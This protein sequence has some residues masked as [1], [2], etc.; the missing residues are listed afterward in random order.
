MQ[1]VIYGDC[2]Q[3]ISISTSSA[4]QQFD[5]WITRHG[6]FRKH[7]HS[8]GII[9]DSQ[10]CRLC[11]IQPEETAKHFI[12]ECE[13]LRVRRRVWQ[14]GDEPQASDGTCTLLSSEISFGCRLVVAQVDF[15]TNLLDDNV[16]LSL[17][18]VAIDKICLL[19]E[20]KSNLLKHYMNYSSCDESHKVAYIDH[21]RYLSL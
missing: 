20:H 1:N 4:I 2:S 5:I 12:P 11:C 13:R 8:L 3:A 15:T 18:I 16:I 21:N 7:L 6:H 17:P 10:E 14:P 19:M 9:N